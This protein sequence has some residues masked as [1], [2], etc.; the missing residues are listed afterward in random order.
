[1]SS[2]VKISL[3]ITCSSGVCGHAST[4]TMLPKCV[5]TCIVVCLPLCTGSMVYLAIP[6]CMMPPF[7]CGNNL[8]S[9]TTLN[10]LC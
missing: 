9:V 2:N 6:C 7:Y 10:S 4:Y 3:L 5:F 8:Y 1:M